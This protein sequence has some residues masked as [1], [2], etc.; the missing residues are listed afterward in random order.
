M[1]K[2]VITAVYSVEE[3]LSFYIINNANFLS[4]MTIYFMLSYV[5]CC[6]A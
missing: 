5:N 4:A 6:S 3:C 1:I 2:I